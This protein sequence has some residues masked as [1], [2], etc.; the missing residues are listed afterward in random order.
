MA[1]LKATG[2]DG[3][4]WEIEATREPFSFGDGLSPVTVVVTVILV[5]FTVFVAFVGGR[6]ILIGF[7]IILL[8]WLGERL[9]NHLRPRLRAQTHDHP[10]EEITWKANRFSGRQ[11]LEERIAHV[12]K[13]GSTL[14]VEPR[15]LTLLSHR[16]I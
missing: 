1:T 10:G 8:I 2:P 4:T 9:S 13:S 5:A 6:L 14:D 12:I 15:G 16:S 7:A 3:R 11:E